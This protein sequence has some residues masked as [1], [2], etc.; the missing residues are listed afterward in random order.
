MASMGSFPTSGRMARHGLGGGQ[1][2]RHDKTVRRLKHR[3]RGPRPRI[4]N[5]QNEHQQ[6]NAQ[7]QPGPP[8]WPK[9]WTLYCLY[10]LLRDIGPLFWA[11]LEVQEHPQPKRQT[12]TIQ[13]QGAS[14]GSLRGGQKGPE[15]KIR[16]FECKIYRLGSLKGGLGQSWRGDLYLHPNLYLHPYLYL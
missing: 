3:H 12:H 5:T 13:S 15:P 1:M 10:S 11:L 4:P 7:G 9:S 14:P 6:P 16:S 2:A 8:K